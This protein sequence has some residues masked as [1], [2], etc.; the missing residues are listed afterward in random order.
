MSKT[1]TPVAI[2]G[3]VIVALI[4]IA[5]VVVLGQLGRLIEHGVE[6]AG[7]RITGTDVSLGSA[8]VSIFDGKGSLHSLHIDN[9]KGFDSKRAFDLGEIGIAVD[10]KSVTSS[11]IHIRSI[12]IDAPELVAEFDAAGRS[13]LNTILEH[14]RATSRGKAAPE[15]GEAPPEETKLIIDEFRFTGAQVQVLAPS[16]ELD[17]VLKLQPVVLRG[18]GGQNGASAADIAAQAMRPIVEAAMRAAMQEYVA[19][20]RDKLGDKAKEK[21][22]DKLFK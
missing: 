8:R 1:G 6:T 9:P 12:V 19:A 4:V 20:Q 13:N 21:M 2:A 17:K 3:G 7:P 11:V 15:K 5:A 16:F 18:L 22:L 10:V 14:A